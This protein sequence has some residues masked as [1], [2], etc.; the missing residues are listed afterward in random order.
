MSENPVQAMKSTQ[1]RRVIFEGRVQGVGF[2]YTTASIA[3]QCN[4]KGYVRNL[5]D[6]S[7]ELVAEGSAQ[8]VKRLL[9]QLAEA[10]PGYIERQ[11]GEEVAGTEPF[12]GFEIRP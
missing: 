3:R 8:N 2:R 5:R 7:V 6:G 9:D 4:I 12:A 1:C 10:F 11:T